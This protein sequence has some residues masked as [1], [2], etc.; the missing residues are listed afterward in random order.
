MVASTGAPVSGRASAPAESDVF[1]AP[2]PAAAQAENLFAPSIMSSP[3]PAAVSNGWAGSAPLNGAAPHDGGRIENLTA[4]RSENSVLFSLS[5]LQSLAAPAPV[6]G[7]S[8]SSTSEGSG[9]IDIR[10]MAATTLKPVSNS[11]SL[12]GGLPAPSA[13]GLDD[14]PAFGTTFGSAA[15]V[16]LPMQ[17]SSGPPKWVWAMLGVVVL[18]V[19]AVIFMAWSVMTTKPV[20]QTVVAPPAPAAPT[21]APVAPAPAG[22]AP[23]PAAALPPTSKPIPESELPP[24]E[25]AAGDK[26]KAAHHEHAASK[27]KHGDKGKATPSESAG[28]KE[29]DVKEAKETK[30][31]VADDAP[32]PKKGSLDDLLDGALNGK[33]TA[34]EDNKR[35]ATVSPEPAAPAGPLSKAAVVAGMNSVKGKVQACYDQFKVPG[36]AMV[37]VVIGKN[38]AVSS[39]SV[40]G[41]FAGTPTGACVEK[42]VK[43][44][45]FPPS[46][47]LTTPYPFNLR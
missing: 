38:G 15:P 14:L 26:A 21:A 33:K 24:R 23:A 42:A 40:T 28:G 4:Q 29:K 36:M 47:G 13:G 11:P 43:S 30:V 27:E 16:L 5:N 31:A 45:K 2:A 22:T 35:S 44:A 3:A 39:A 25:E 6:R 18:L 46:D 37:T 1:A 32:K 41:K 19:G 10:A 20:V 8:T 34:R 12:P 17:S 9:L 7:P